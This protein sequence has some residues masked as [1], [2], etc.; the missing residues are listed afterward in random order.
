MS[1]ITTENTRYLVS[2]CH[3]DHHV[4]HH[5]RD[6]EEPV[7]AVRASTSGWIGLWPNPAEGGLNAD[8][9]WPIRE[10]L[11]AREIER[12]GIADLADTHRG[13]YLTDVTDIRD[14]PISPADVPQ[15]ENLQADRIRQLETELERVKAEH[16]AEITRLAREHEAFI[17]TAS[18]ILGSEADSHDLCSVYDGIAERAGLRRRLRRYDV[19]IEV[20]YRQTITVMGHDQDEAYDTVREFTTQDGWRYTPP[21]PFAGADVE[22]FGGV[23]NLGVEIVD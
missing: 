3:E 11:T 18:E 9:G 21:S 13:W 17:D 2:C 7:L 14:I 4:P 15:I 22:D 6:D 5:Y 16:T 10:H 12:C 8:Y 20:T 23:Y 1:V 19:E